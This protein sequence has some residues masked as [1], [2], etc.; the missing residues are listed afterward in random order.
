MTPDLR[1]Y[2]SRQPGRCP[3]CCAHV[4]TQGHTPEC[5]T[6]APPPVP[7]DETSAVQTPQLLHYH[8]RV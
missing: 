8:D 2:L 4:A 3:D 1:A 5:P 7:H 6:M